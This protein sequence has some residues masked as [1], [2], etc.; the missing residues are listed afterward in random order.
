MPVVICVAKMELAGIGFNCEVVQALQEKLREEM[1]ILE[2]RAYQLAGR[3]FCLTSPADTA[4]VRICVCN[5]EK[6]SNP[7]I[8][9]VT[10]QSIVYSLP[11][12][13]LGVCC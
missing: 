7:H 13:C 5:I 3:S 4:R 1:S 8:S 12:L 6:Y 2:Q 11:Y 10:F 9:L